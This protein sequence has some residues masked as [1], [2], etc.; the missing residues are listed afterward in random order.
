MRRRSAFLT[1]LLLALMPSTAFASARVTKQDRIATRM[2]LEANYAYERM[3]AGTVAASNAAVET[4]EDQLERECPGVA[5]D[6]PKGEGEGV[7]PIISVRRS[8]RRVGEMNRE[9]RQLKDMEAELSDAL[10]RAQTGPY[11]EA[12]LSFAHTIMSLRWSEKGLTALLHIG[13]ALIEERLRGAPLQVCSDLR[14]WAASNY[15]AL[16][17]A[18]RALARQREAA[19]E[20]IWSAVF[21]L[22]L[23]HPLSLSLLSLQGFEDARERALVRRTDRVEAVQEKATVGLGKIERQ[24]LGELGLTAEENPES[25]ELH[26]SHEIQEP[27]SKGSTVIGHGKTLAG[28]TYT[29]EVDP[30]L[31]LVEKG[32]NRCVGITIDETIRN[33]GSGTAECVPRSRIEAP[34]LTCDE[35]LLTIEAQTLPSARHVRLTLSD[36]RQITSPVAIVPPKLGGPVGYYHQALWGPSPIPVSLAELGARGRLLHSV[37]L[38]RRTGCKRPPPSNPRREIHVIGHGQVPHGPRFLIFG[39]RSPIFAGS[40]KLGSRLLSARRIEIKALV[41]NMGATLSNEDEARL[42]TLD[43]NQRSRLFSWQLATGCQ[44]HEYAILYGLLREPQDHVFARTASG[45]V[46]LRRVR[47]PASF[48]TK[49]VLA[50][51]VLPSVPSEAVA[52][53]QAGKTLTVVKLGS[54]AKRAREV[55]EGEAEPP[56]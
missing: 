3:Q 18:T 41:L 42:V 31:H 19:F 6:A 27:R 9:Q 37:T 21:R 5:D 22:R 43:R 54:Q 46:S 10:Y 26:E 14:S 48:N 35:G 38:P 47:M 15:T 25:H 17:A 55:C 50:Y 4:L 44:P 52:R 28:G 1:V 8:A 13:A 32:P 34:K 33:I 56:L 24:L 51:A 53:S 45:L 7:Q 40:G 16:P 2:Y 29:I 12:A 11:R 23:F 39:R 20:S 36:G 30:G 49:D